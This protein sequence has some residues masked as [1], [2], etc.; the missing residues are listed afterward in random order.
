MQFG[1]I[2]AIELQCILNDLPWQRCACS[3]FLMFICHHRLTS[4]VSAFG[5]FEAQK[6]RNVVIWPEWNE[7][8]IS[9]EKWV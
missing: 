4:A 8:D 6:R 5:G 3:W 1:T 7:A 2:F 9:S